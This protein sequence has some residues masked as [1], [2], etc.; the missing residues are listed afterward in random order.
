MTKEQIAKDFNEGRVVCVDET[1]ILWQCG[2]CGVHFATKKEAE[3][4]E[5]LCKNDP[6]E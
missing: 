3:D 4:C 2:K 6:E 5:W 1:T